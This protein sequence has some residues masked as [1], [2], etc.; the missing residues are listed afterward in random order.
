MEFANGIRESNGCELV[1]RKCIIYS[2][3]DG[4]WEDCSTRGLIPEEPS[5]MKQGVH[6][7]ENGDCLKGI[8]VFNVPIGEPGY[9]EAVLWS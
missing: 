3:D 2:L 4:A 8:T 9:G 5:L 6:A 1:A 7:T